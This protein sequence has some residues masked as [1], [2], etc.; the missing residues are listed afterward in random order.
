MIS[1]LGGCIVLYAMVLTQYL[2]RVPSLQTPLLVEFFATY[3]TN[4]PNVLC[5]LYRGYV[6]GTLCQ[7]RCPCP[8]YK[9]KQ[10]AV[11]F[12]KCQQSA[13]T[14]QKCQ[15]TAVTFQKCQQTAYI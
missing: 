9:S 15:Q 11:I 6:L 4:C 10:T 3:G 1:I 5:L 14:F 7:A 2:A 13:V 12:Q 8:A